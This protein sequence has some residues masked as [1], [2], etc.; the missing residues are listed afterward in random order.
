MG[1]L[2]SF[3]LFNRV[4]GS[5]QMMKTFPTIIDCNI[6]NH[7]GIMGLFSGFTMIDCY[8]DSVHFKFHTC[9]DISV[10]FMH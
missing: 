10:S 4:S 8:Q 9:F 3:L 5:A 6:L 1:T 2:G 7:I